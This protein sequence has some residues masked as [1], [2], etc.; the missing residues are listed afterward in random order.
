M[1]ISVVGV[2]IIQ[3][4]R[5]HIF[6]GRIRILCLNVGLICKYILCINVIDLMCY[7]IYITLCWD[8]RWLRFLIN[9][10]II[11]C[12]FIYYCISVLY[13]SQHIPN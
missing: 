4:Y 9:L 13:K 11:I 2:E 5:Q 6:L 8:G 7:I 3:I 10:I 1:F 12:D